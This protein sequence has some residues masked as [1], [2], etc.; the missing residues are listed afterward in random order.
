MRRLLF[1]A[2]GAVL[3]ASVTGL[4]LGDSGLPQQQSALAR[5]RIYAYRDW[6]STS[7]RVN[8]D[9]VVEIRAEGRWLYTPGEYHGPQGHARYPAP[10]FYP[11]SGI[12]GGALIGRL[13]EGGAPF[14]VGE[15][16]TMLATEPGTLYLRINDDMLG[17]N[18]GWVEV[19]IRVTTPE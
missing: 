17:D 14:W 3:L 4:A 11:I 8:P 18:D 12:P 9:E 1:L 7:V 19:V 10:S 16:T 5:P 15:H 2:L 13:G 6:Q